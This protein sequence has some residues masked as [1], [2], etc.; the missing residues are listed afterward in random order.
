MKTTW[1]NVTPSHLFI[2]CRA[3]CIPLSGERTGGLCNR[4]V[5]GSHWGR[6]AQKMH[7]MPQPQVRYKD[8]QNKRCERRI[9]HGFHILVD[10]ALPAKP[11][12]ISKW[13]LHFQLKQLQLHAAS[14]EAQVFFVRIWDG[15]RIPWSK[16]PEWF[17]C[18]SL[19]RWT[20]ASG[21]EIRREEALTSC[22]LWHLVSMW[23]RDS[24]TVN[25]CWMFSDG[26][27]FFFLHVDLT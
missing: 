1:L 10:T 12:V 7:N 11:Q 9:S 15:W 2:F 18:S 4:V 14:G 17:P 16:L 20:A 27:F 13:Q 25:E 21:V 3:H 8:W 19:P 5:I 6:E 23:R 26:C 24:S 22:F